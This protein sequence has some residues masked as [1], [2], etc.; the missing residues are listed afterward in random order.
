MSVWQFASPAPLQGEEGEL[1]SIRITVEAFLL[2]DLLD[3]LAGAP[4]PINPE[5]R[6]HSVLR[7][8]GRDLPAVTVEFPAWRNKVGELE[9]RLK[10][11]GAE[12][13]AGPMLAAV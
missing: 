11:F 12:V 10:N 2:E 1:L 9:Q 8:G 5:I 3:T 6:H 4:F 7:R 13:S